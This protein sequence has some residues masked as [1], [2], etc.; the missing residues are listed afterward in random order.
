MISN[1][2]KEYR[3][4]VFSDLK[5]NY[6]GVLKDGTVDV[7]GLTG[8]KSHTPPF[9]RRAFYQ[10]L[11]ILSNVNTAS[12]FTSAKVKIIEVI[13]ENA[14]KLEANEIPLPDFT[15]NVMV[16]KSPEK[17]GIKLADNFKNFSIDGT[18]NDIPSFKG[19]PQH[20]KAEVIEW[21]WQGSKGWSY[22]LIC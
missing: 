13:K 5:K 17:Y 7:K 20:I 15:F 8:K 1:L 21:Q 4:V 9:I 11:D 12:D 3:Y 19:L 22:Y 18:G 16:N 10:V 14:L 2:D 6:L